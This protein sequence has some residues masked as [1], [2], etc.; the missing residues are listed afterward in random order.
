MKYLLIVMLMIS[1]LSS[2]AQK[3]Y[4]FNQL[5]SLQNIEKKN[6]IVFVSASWCNYCKAMDETVFKEPAII[7]L[8]DQQ[9]YFVELNAEDQTPIVY[10]NHKFSFNPSLGFH[11]MAI[12]LANKQ[13]LTFPSIYILTNANEILYQHKGFIKA[14]NLFKVLNN[15]KY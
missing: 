15:I 10:Q 1:S 5:D 12:I 3:I 9:Y 7:K 13:K 11:E 4:S 14:T 6:I 8:L 2:K